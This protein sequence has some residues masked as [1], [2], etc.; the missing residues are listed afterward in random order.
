MISINECFDENT[1]TEKRSCTNELHIDDQ[2]AVVF[3]N[4]TSFVGVKAVVEP[5]CG[6]NEIT[7]TYC[8]NGG[9]YTDT[10]TCI[11]PDGFDGPYCEMLGIGF[12]GDGWALY[13]SFEAFERTNIRLEISAEKDDGLIFYIGPTNVKPEPIVRGLYWKIC[14]IML[15]LSFFL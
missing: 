13:R 7:L 8:Y 2:P 14:S 6:S 10:G 12:R 15:C 3:T 1:C 5:T 11:C 4:K 9:T